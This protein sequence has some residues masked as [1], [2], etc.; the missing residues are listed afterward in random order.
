MI[1]FAVV[2][3]FSMVFMHPVCLGASFL[4]AFRYALYLNGGRAWRFNLRFM[5]PLLI[6]MALINPA[7]NH[8]GATILAYFSNGNP[9]TLESILY[10]LAAAF[11]LITVI[12][13]F[14]CF[15]AIMTSDKF[16][17]LFGRLIPALSLIL[18]ISLRFVPRYK[19]RIRA[20][21]D[22]QRCMGRDVSNGNILSRARRGV[23]ILSVMVTWALENAI[24]TADSMKCRGYG[25]PNRTAF[26]VFRFGRRDALILVA[27]F[28]LAGYVLAGAMAGGLSFLY[29]PVTT[30]VWTGF[31][32]ISIYLCFFALCAIPMCINVW[33]DYK[34]KSLNSKV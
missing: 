3:A 9:L 19:A 14:S 5:L 13:W 6:V 15:N 27:I 12:A 32:T 10:G 28:A 7:F 23:A 22:A 26:S 31:R 11:M 8:R 33:E 24:E 20:I 34:W 21:A 29:F 2:L 18:A 25:L 16:V 30:G 17:Y 1:Y 4:C